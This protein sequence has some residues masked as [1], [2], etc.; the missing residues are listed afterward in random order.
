M[1]T[2][3]FTLENVINYDYCVCPFV[4]SANNYAEIIGVSFG[5]AIAVLILVLI[6]LVI[7]RRRS[8]DSAGED[9]PLTFDNP[10]YGDASKTPTELENKN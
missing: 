10:N 2:Y 7:Y 1:A 3:L 8:Y 4:D 9:S 5:C 6:L